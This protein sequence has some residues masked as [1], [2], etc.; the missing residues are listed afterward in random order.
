VLPSGLYFVE[1]F[2]VGLFVVL[3]PVH[4]AALA[5]A[6]PALRGRYL[7]L[8]LFPFALGQLGSYRLARRFGAL[9]TLAA[10]SV[11]YGLAFAA[12]GRLEATALLAWMVLLGTLAAVIFPP[13]L[14]LVAEWST[15]RTRA[16]AMAAFNLAGSLGFA[17]G[18]VAGAAIL[19]FAGYP[20]A[21][22]TAGGLA[23][24][25]GVAVALSGRRLGG[26]G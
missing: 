26:G 11:F 12:I 3:F 23:V 18:P 9:P 22:A 2:S 19:R 7:A 6:D 10:G 14:A 17:A 4:L 1:R 5:G 13:T 24:A 8:F 15:P 21:F 20:A 25:A 16:S